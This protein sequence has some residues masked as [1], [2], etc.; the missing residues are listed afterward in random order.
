MLQFILK[1]QFECAKKSIKIKFDIYM[2]SIIS[3]CNI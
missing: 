2:D 3:E 1:N